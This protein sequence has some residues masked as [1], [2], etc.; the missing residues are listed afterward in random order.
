MNTNFIVG[1]IR[2]DGCFNLSN[3]GIT[4]TITMML[5][6]AFRGVFGCGRRTVVDFE[7]RSYSLDDG[8]CSVLPR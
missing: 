5:I 6:V 2:L 3:G 8:F 1:T 7:I 4:I